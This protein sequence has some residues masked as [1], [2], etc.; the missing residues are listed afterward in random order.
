MKNTEFAFV[1]VMA[2]SCL[3]WEAAPQEWSQWRGPSR[4]GEIAASGWPDSL[5]EK[6]LAKKWRVELQPSYSGPIIADGK[7]FTTETA[8]R[9]FEVV[10]AFRQSDGKQLWQT[11]WEGSLS[12]P[13]F[14][15]ANGDWIRATPAY[16]TKR[17]YVAGMRDLL[18]CLNADTGEVIWKID[19]VKEFETPAPSF[20]FVSSPLIQGDSVYVQAGGAFVRIN[21]A[22]G[23]VVWKTLDDGGGMFGSAFSSPVFTRLHGVEQLVVQTRAKL[24]GVNPDDGKVLWSIEIP[25]FRGMNI[26]TPTIW[27]DQ[28]FT[29]TYGG[30]SILLKPTQDDTSTTG[31]KVEEVWSNKT[32][33]YMSS[34]IVADDHCYLH[35]RNKRFICIEL[36][37]G[38][39]KWTTKPFGGYWSMI[40]SGDKI[41]ALDQL[42]EL[43]LIRI[44]SKEFQLIERR[45]IS[46]ES[47]WAH[48]AVV[49][50]EVYVRELKALNAFRWSNSPQ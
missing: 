7:V 24:A 11:K 6:S 41:L 23:K 33:G 42:G 3:A 39:I 50:D 25:A 37:S 30:K 22:D 48:L 45:K 29:S 13:F 20:G 12:V 46:E 16:D 47:T 14:A 35:L 15:K 5:H 1:L 10:T 28:I 26:L 27:Q 34:P 36:K 9:K 31:W 17:L 38:E 18:V 32:Q 44:D 8:D 19:F 21:K 40:R 49:G 43:L 2:S 4:T